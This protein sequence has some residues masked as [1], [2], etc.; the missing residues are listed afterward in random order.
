MAKP[1]QQRLPEPAA[2]PKL[3]RVDRRIDRALL[4]LRKRTPAGLP[5]K[6]TVMVKA[7]AARAAGQAVKGRPTD[8]D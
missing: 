2:D 1:Q 8:G 3:A 4:L 6:L 5:E 7:I